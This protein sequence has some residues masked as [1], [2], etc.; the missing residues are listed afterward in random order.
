MYS[1]LVT[2]MTVVSP[3]S[4]SYNQTL[5]VSAWR[6]QHVS[7][8]TGPPLH[9]VLELRFDDACTVG[10]TTPREQTRWL[11]PY[12][13]HSLSHIL[14]PSSHSLIPSPSFLPLPPPFH[15]LPLLPAS[16]LPPPSLLLPICLFPHL[17]PFTLLPFSLP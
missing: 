12:T 1:G 2:P 7:T 8:A 4:P 9:M 17:T 15:F 6:L 5:T 16:L 10:V 13:C 11:Q 14:S 3:T